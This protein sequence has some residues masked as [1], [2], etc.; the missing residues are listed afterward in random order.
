MPPNH[1]WSWTF[2]ASDLARIRSQFAHGGAAKSRVLM[3]D[4]QLRAQNESGAHCLIESGKM[5]TFRKLWLRERHHAQRQNVQKC[6]AH[7]KRH[8][9]PPF[10]QRIGTDLGMIESIHRRCVRRELRSLYLQPQLTQQPR[11]GAAGS[12]EQILRY[13]VGFVEEFVIRL[14]VLNIRSYSLRNCVQQ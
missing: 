8:R 14:R 2:R 9:L 1:S 12:T 11:R 6:H 3:T 4:R 13:A 7:K 10:D 5:L